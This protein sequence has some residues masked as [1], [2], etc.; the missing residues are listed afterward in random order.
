MKKK[1]TNKIFNVGSSQPIQIKKVINK[2]NTKIGLGKP[3]FG[4]IRMRKDEIKKSFP[5]ISRI[6]KEFKWKP[7]ISFERGI[8]NTIFFYENQKR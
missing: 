3:K 2:I 4:Q 5:N 7:K 6:K 8:V 1:A